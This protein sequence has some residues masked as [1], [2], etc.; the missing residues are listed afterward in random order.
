MRPRVVFREVRQEGGGGDGAGGAAAYVLQVGKVGFELFAVFGKQGQ[1]PCLVA[2]LARCGQDFVG[3]L[4]RVGQKAAGN[5]AECDDARAGECGDIDYGGGFELFGMAQRVAQ[6]QAAFGIGVQD[7]DGGAVHGRYHVAGFAGGRVGHV[8]AG[9]DDGGQVDGQFGF[10]G[11][12]ECADDACRT[13]HVVFHFVHRFARLERDAAAVEGDAFADEYDRGGVFVGRAAPVQFDEVRVLCAAFGHRPERTHVFADM[14][15]I[16]DFGGRTEFFGFG[17]GGVGQIFRGA[18]VGGGVAQVFAQVD[19]VELGFG[20][21]QGG[22]HGVG[23]FGVE[24]CAVEFGGFRVFFE[25]VESVSG[26]SEGE[27]EGFGGFGGLV[28][29]EAVQ[30]DVQVFL[31]LRPY[32]GFGGGFFKRVAA[33]VFRQRDRHGFQFAR[34]GGLGGGKTFA[35]GQR[36]EQQA[37]GFVVGCVFTIA[38]DIK[39]CAFLMR[40]QGGGF[41]AKLHFYSFRLAV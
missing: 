40:L 25:T 3:Q 33:V 16:V 29:V 7:F 13:A 20:P 1:L 39:Q 41:C 34:F 15:F 31:F 12:C 6:Y 35:F 24:G 19:A 5:V 8:F 30:A 37:G 38:A 22:L 32:G 14:V 28:W 26:L 2:A 36:F 10:G 4:L 11:G 18:D 27:R 21:I 9:G 23:V 17:T